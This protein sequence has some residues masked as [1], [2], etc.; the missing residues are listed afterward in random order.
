MSVATRL[1]SRLTLNSLI[2][3]QMLVGRPAGWG[4]R[5]KYRSFPAVVTYH[6][7]SPEPYVHDMN[8]LLQRMLLHRSAQ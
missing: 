3:L 5:P 4:R 8:I 1:T 7:L 2:S 6:A